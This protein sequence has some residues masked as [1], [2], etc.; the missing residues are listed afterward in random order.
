[1]N[2]RLSIL[3]Y[4]FKYDNQSSKQYN[5]WIASIKANT[6]NTTIDTD[7]DIITL[8]SPC[9]NRFIIQGIKPKQPLAFDIEFVSDRS[10]V[11][12]DEF[13]SHN[14]IK[15]LFDRIGYHKFEISAKEYSDIYFN[16]R[17]I[18]AEKIQ[19]GVG[20]IGYKCTVSCDAPWAWQKE[21]NAVYNFTSTPSFIKYI[22]NSDYEDY[23]IPHKVEITCGTTGGTIAITNIN[24][25]NNVCQ[26]TGLSANE[27]I[28]IDKFC[29]IASST[30]NKRYGNWNQHQLRFINGENTLNVAGDIIKLSIVCD[31]ARRVGY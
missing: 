17:F 5:I 13:K 26:F 20:L 12:I 16:C 25:N 10:N 18:K 22:C 1:M 9:D 31:N 28:S 7:K 30:E 2:S 4:Y 23:L 15:W 21:D 14:I 19:A 8:Y 11:A 29:Q 3:G 24:D 6:N 27:V